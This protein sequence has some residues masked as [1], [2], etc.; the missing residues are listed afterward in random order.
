M[1]L[2][3]LLEPLGGTAPKFSSLAHSHSFF[4][5]HGTAIALQCPSQAYPPPNFK[6]VSRQKH[7]MKNCEVESI[8]LSKLVRGVFVKFINNCNQS[9][10]SLHKCKLNI[11][12]LFISNSFQFWLTMLILYITNRTHGKFCAE[13]A[14]RFSFASNDSFIRIFDCCTMSGSRKSCSKF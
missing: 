9:S 14:L 4:K 6:W 10:G 2:M 1:I 8:G 11:N 3:H 5:E 13:F 12:Q 7:I